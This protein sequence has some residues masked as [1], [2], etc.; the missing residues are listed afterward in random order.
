MKLRTKIHLY[1]TLLMLVLLIVMN[2]GVYLLYEQ[3]AINTEYKQLKS[4]SEELLTAF[5]NLSDVTDPSIVLRAYMPTNGAVHVLNETGMKFSRLK[6][7]PL[8][9]FNSK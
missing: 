3:L 5:N 2:S 8:N 9:L 7:F 4:D 6:P 1:T